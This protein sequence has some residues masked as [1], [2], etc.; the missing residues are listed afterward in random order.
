MKK[1]PYSKSIASAIRSF[2]TED[3]WH[4]RFDEE[5]ATYRMKLGLESDLDHVDIYIRVYDESFTVSAVSP[6]KVKKDPAKR[7]EMAEF[8][9]RANY[10]L[11]CGG[12][13]YDIRDGEILYK[14]YVSCHDI[15]PSQ[16]MVRHS[17]YIPAMMFDK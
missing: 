16:E 6:I 1:R 4:F 7:R 14:V 2:L 13:Q 12:F 15:V 5:D 9:C 8:V 11:M 10:G 3:D 17:L